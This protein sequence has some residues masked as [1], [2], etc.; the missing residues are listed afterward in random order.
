M[1][2]GFISENSLQT[3]KEKGN[4]EKAEILLFGFN[5]IGEVSYEKELKGESGFFEEAALLSK[6]EH[7]VVVSGC[8]T[9][10]L[11]HKRRS[12]VVA[13]NGKLL[14]ISD[15]LYAIDGNGSG[16]ELRIYTT[17]VG[18]MGVVVG[19][20]LYFSDTM[21]ALSLCG[22][23]FIVCPFDR[24][25]SS[26][27]SVYL[28]VFAHSYG[29]PIYLCGKGFCMVA[30]VKGEI[31]FSSPVSPCFFTFEN[32]KEYHLIERRKCVKILKIDN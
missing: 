22:C 12:A 5:G 20:D 6:S 30:D 1:R 9:N 25:L 31:A 24:V 18:K 2:V 32:R 4:N 15:A 21:R 13:E 23:D 28:R 29:F 17:K 8:V 14:G 27:E 26:L 7:C 16:A 11:G 19:E 10:T 3:Y